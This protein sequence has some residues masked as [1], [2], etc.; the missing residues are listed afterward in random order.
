[1]VRVTKKEEG[2]VIGNR[3]KANKGYSTLTPKLF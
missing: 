1:M 3:A 2:I